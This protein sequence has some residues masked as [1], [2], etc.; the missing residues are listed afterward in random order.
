MLRML[1]PISLMVLVG[2]QPT[3]SPVESDLEDAS[4]RNGLNSERRAAI[5]RCL[6]EIGKEP[7]P[8]VLTG[9]DAPMNQ[10]E[11]AE[12]DECMDK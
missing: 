5:N 7:L 8:E 4:K 11:S 2:C 6:Q 3:P 10:A 9:F 12:F 1:L